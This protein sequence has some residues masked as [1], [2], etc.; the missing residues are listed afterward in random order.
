M[1][2]SDDRIEV[3][4]SFNT[5]R[6]IEEKILIERDNAFIFGEKASVARKKAVARRLYSQR[7]LK[8]ASRKK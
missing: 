1:G 8:K 6:G 4:P 3:S 7:E 5:A 2:R